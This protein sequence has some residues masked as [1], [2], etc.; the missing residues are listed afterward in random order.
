[1]LGIRSFPFGA[2]GLF[3]GAN[4]LLVLGKVLLHTYLPPGDD[5]P[6][7]T[8]VVFVQMGWFTHQPRKK[9]RSLG[10]WPDALTNIQ[11]GP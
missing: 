9:W 11:G 6:N 5:D 1:M 7:L 4:L 3:S 10:D 8:I 2:K